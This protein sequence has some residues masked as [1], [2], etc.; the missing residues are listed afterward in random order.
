MGFSFCV[1]NL[2]HET[3]E[4]IC[5]VFKSIGCYLINDCSSELEG[6]PLNKHYF[7]H[8]IRMLEEKL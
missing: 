7:F 3:F 8:I 5:L 2:I 4:E 1:E 6:P